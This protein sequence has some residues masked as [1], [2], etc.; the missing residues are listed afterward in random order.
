MSKT[1]QFGDR[2]RVDGLPGEFLV[3][4][5]DDLFADSVEVYSSSPDQPTYQ[6]VSAERVSALW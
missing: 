3:S 2:V 6:W 1:L 5:Y 4:D